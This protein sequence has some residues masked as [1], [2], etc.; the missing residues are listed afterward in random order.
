[1]ILIFAKHTNGQISFIGTCESESQMRVIGESIVQSPYWQDVFFLPT[2]TPSIYEAAQMWTMGYWLDNPNLE[3][4][5][6][7]DPLI[8]AAMQDAD[9]G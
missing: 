4:K 9:N 1:M 8:L 6:Q 2:N 7:D 3:R 5:P